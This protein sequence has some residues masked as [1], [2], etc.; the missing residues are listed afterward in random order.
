[1][2]SG[3]PFTAILAMNDNVAIGAYRAL[4]DTGLQVPQ[5]VSVISCD[6]FYTAEYLVPR[7]TSVDQHNELFGRFIINALLGAIHDRAED[8]VLSYKPEL[9]LRE[10]CAAP[11]LP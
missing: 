2:D 8:V 11:A 9:V 1:M 10:S 3:T 6:Q 5:D 4:A 7:L